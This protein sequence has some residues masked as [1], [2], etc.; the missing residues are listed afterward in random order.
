LR[1]HHAD[2]AISRFCLRIQ[3]SGASDNSETSIGDDVPSFD[4]KITSIAIARNLPIWG[5]P[6]PRSSI[7]THVNDRLTI[8][9]N[10]GPLAP[11]GHVTG[12][13]HV[14]VHHSGSDF[15]YSGSSPGSHVDVIV[16]TL[17]HSGIPSTAQASITFCWCQFAPA[18]G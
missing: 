18:F 12:T 2:R 1:L 15:L 7:R 9:H 17:D 11:P 8:L 16:A 5:S 4:R 10:P 14:R 3:L 13:A 6:P